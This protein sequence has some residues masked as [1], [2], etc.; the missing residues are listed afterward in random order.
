[1]T[2]LTQR[3]ASFG[4]DLSNG[5]GNSFGNME[6][7]LRIAHKRKYPRGSTIIYAG[8]PSDSIF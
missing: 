8:E 1:M 5:L 7:F 4:Q 3:P 2:S 6:E